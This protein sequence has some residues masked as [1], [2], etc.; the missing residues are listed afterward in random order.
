[1]LTVA[2]FAPRQLQTFT[3]FSSKSAGKVR[4]MYIQ[5]CQYS[6]RYKKDFFSSEPAQTPARLRQQ[7][8]SNISKRCLIE[9]CGCSVKLQQ[10]FSNKGEKDNCQRAAS[11]QGLLTKLFAQPERSR[12]VVYLSL[13]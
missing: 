9:Q 12:R 13:D 1:M 2:T 7:H 6:S 10:I 8:L 11:Q 5:N 3:I 4:T